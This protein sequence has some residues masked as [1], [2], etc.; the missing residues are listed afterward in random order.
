EQK[1]LLET[2]EQID[3]NAKDLASYREKENQLRVDNDIPPPRQTALGRNDPEHP[4]FVRQATVENQ[5]VVL[6]DEIEERTSEL[7]RL[8]EM[9][10]L[11]PVYVDPAD[12]DLG[13]VQSAEIERIDQRIEK[14]RMEIL[15]GR[16]G[17]EHSERK[18][19]EREIKSLRTQ[20]EIALSQVEGTVF[21]RLDEQKNPDRLAL[22]REIDTKAIELRQQQLRL[23]QR[24]ETRLTLNQRAQG[25]QEAYKQL[26]ELAELKQELAASNQTL[27]LKKNKLEIQVKMLDGPQGDPFEELRKPA[28]PGKATSPNPWIISIGSIL[29]GLAIGLGLAI[30]LEYSKNCFRSEREL[31]RAMPHPVL[32][33]V[34]AI[35]TRR[36]RARAAVVRTVLG[37][38]SL[39]FVIG[40]VFVTWA[41]A[42]NRNALTDSLVDAIDGFQRMLK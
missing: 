38:G 9:R 39:A 8:R 32:G 42:Q 22:T 16:W 36:E 35:R 6:T 20:R 15:E 27:V 1:E 4:V 19:R 26:E 33:T 25:I 34:N 21:E 18:S 17:P 37:G 7:E 24:K 2:I 14:L 28:V 10:D 31:N 41:Y 29:F 5:I 11:L 13:T 12:L 23:A 30:L 3:R 40:V